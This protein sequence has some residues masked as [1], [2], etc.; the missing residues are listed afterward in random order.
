VPANAST[1]SAPAACPAILQ[2]RFDR[3]QDEQPQD[4]CQY[5][6]RVVLVVNTASYCGFAQHYKGR[7]ALYQGRSARPSQAGAAQGARS[8]ATETSQ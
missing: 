7:D 2:H 5:A 4:L 1:P 6:G 8:A 3:L